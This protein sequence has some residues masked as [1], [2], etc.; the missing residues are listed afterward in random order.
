ML[1]QRV[2]PLHLIAAA[3]LVG[4]SACASSKPATKPSIPSTPASFEPV[5][6]T[7]DITVLLAGIPQH[8]IVLGNPTAPVTL[9]YFSDVA[10]PPSREIT[11][12][13]LASIIRNWVR[14][15]KLRIEYRSVEEGTATEGGFINQQADV[16]AAGTQDKL[17]NYL[18]YF[19][20][21]QYAMPSNDRDSCFLE[22]SFLRTIARTTPGLSFAQWTKDARGKLLARE[23][24]ADERTAAEADLEDPSFLIGRTGAPTAMKLDQFS[25]TDPAYSEVTHELLAAKVYL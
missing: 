19:Y 15:G 3:A 17:W 6:T 23:V 16:L 20:R 8:G 21:A 7:R 4:V 2:R 11:A 18:E 9:Q 25:R 1:R 13:P 10:C 22:E 14:P 5:I 24:V 12:G